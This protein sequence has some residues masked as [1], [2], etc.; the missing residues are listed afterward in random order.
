MTP[1]PISREERETWATRYDTDRMRRLLAALDAGEALAKAAENACD[2]PAEGCPCLTC[3]DL[4]K[5]WAALAGW[6]A[7]VKGQGG[8]EP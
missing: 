3:E 2:E 5:F 7:H 8:S 1:E 6:R 4:R